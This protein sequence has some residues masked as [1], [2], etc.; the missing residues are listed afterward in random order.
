MKRLKCYFEIMLNLSALV[1]NSCFIHVWTF[2]QMMSRFL[3]HAS[4]K[5]FDSNKYKEVNFPNDIT[6]M[7]CHMLTLLCCSFTIFIV[8]SAQGILWS[9]K[10]FFILQNILMLLFSM[11]QTDQYN[12]FSIGTVQKYLSSK[13]FRVQ[14]FCLRK[15]WVNFI[16]NHMYLILTAEFVVILFNALFYN[17]QNIL[18]SPFC[19]SPSPSVCKTS[20]WFK[21]CM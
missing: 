11:L 13:H 10:A 14:P 12:L 4:K 17:G 7:R 3:R 6:F 2:H 9:W 19:I 5:L 16:E 15:L 18:G 1:F 21:I 8:I 20:H